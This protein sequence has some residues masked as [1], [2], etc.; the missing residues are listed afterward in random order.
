MIELCKGW[1]RC[2]LEKWL[3]HDRSKSIADRLADRSSCVA[4]RSEPRV[5]ETRCTGFRK[6]K[7]VCATRWITLVVA[8]WMVVPVT[9]WKIAVTI[10]V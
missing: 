7:R 2:F 9:G 8:R 5:A 3:G 10:A 4:T 1:R 6:E